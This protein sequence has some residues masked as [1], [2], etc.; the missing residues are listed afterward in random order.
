MNI[1]KALHAYKSVLEAQSQF[2]LSL[3]NR[4]LFG[5]A[6]GL[7][8]FD[9]DSSGKSSSHDERAPWA[10]AEALKKATIEVAKLLVQIHSEM[11]FAKREAGWAKLGAKDFG[12]VSRLLRDIFVP[13]SGMESLVAVVRLIEKRHDSDAAQPSAGL[14]KSTALDSDAS[15]GSEKEHWDWIFRQLQGPTRRLLLVMIEGLDHALY[16][17]EFAKR[18]HSA[19]MSDIEAKGPEQPS[20]EGFADRLERA[21]QEFLHQREGP[22]KEWCTSKGMDS[23]PSGHNPNS[24][25]DSLH[26]RHQSQL[27]LLLDVS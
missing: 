2:M 24:S 6:D 16:T 21:I 9:G 25:N 22:L 18:P 19:V 15:E 26:E 13:V 11:R 10:E 1:V 7:R 3:P 23:L 17:L 5:V 20:D 14:P 4:D 27:Y 12:K 8:S